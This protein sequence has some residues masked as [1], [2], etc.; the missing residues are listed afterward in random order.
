M[1]Y[2]S[3]TLYTTI[4]GRFLMLTFIVFLVA[5]GL[6][7]PAHAS[8]PDAEA[9][10]SEMPSTTEYTV[11]GIENSEQIYNLAPFELIRRSSQNTEPLFTHISKNGL[12][13]VTANIEDSNGKTDTKQLS[14]SWSCW[15]HSTTVTNTTVCGEY[16]ETGIIQLPN[17]SYKWG[18]GV[19]SVLMLP[20]KVYDPDEPVEIV[21]LDV[22]QNDFNAFSLMQNSSMDSILNTLRK[23]WPCYD[24]DKNEYLCPVVY[25]TENVK[26]ET[27]GVYYF[28]VTFE[29]PLNCRFS[30]SLN[31][32]TFSIPVSVQAPG[33]PRLDVSYISLWTTYPHF[34]FPWI[35]SGIS[36]DT[37]EI[38]ISENNGEW[39]EMVIDD[40]VFISSNFLHIDPWMLTIG[41]SYRIQAK[42]EGGQTGIAS[43]T[44]TN[45]GLS[46][47][48]Y[49]EGDRDGGDTDGNPP[50]DSENNENTNNTPP[51][52]STNNGNSSTGTD[53]N[54]TDTDSKPATSIPASVETLPETDTTTLPKES[55]DNRE[56]L[57]DD[58]E[59]E[60]AIETSTPT[61]TASDREEPYL[62]GSEINRMIRNLGTARFS[63]ETIML[64]IPE[65]AIASL[66][67]RDTDRLLVTVLPL[68]NN[69]FTIDI[70]KNDVAITNVSSMQ[71][72]L[73][74]QPPENT[75]PVLINEDKEKVADGDYEPQ[76][77]LA[78]FTIN[79]TGTFYI[80]DEE[81]P[82]Q[83][84]F[85]ANTLTATEI[86]TSDKETD[87][88]VYTLIAIAATV[89]ICFAAATIFIHTKRRRR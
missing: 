19:S 65:D 17:D 9:T 33:Q 67:I 23:E 30:E 2:R 22:V 4:Y 41:N 76:T 58:T 63:A 7:I 43:F 68:E 24:A 71:I 66:G 18:E 81:V 55:S 15:D 57:P 25:N 59:N 73:P 13:N 54:S 8:E 77:G 32:P 56:D 82:L 88:S 46:D 16:I 26:E 5:F 53:D 84:S 50:T 75:T 83:D 86:S 70:S 62:L 35:T 52:D 87:T 10:G 74:Y 14:V 85:A 36:L 79:E 38:W 21:E 20:V 28:T 69:G 64:D 48:G 6:S 47:Q 45:E 49:L 44:Y 37:M 12:L 1:K 34:Y 51:T 78:S 39:R 29:E 11:V 61:D 27:V 89:M 40:E 80:Q 42:Y 3:K 31:I 72:S 60:L